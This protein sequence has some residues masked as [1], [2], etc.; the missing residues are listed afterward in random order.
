MCH[1]VAQ[2]INRARTSCDTIYITTHNGTDLFN[3]FN[4]IYKC[5]HKFLKIIS[6]LKSNY[7]NFKAGI[8][9]EIRYGITKHNM[10]E[11]TLILLLM[12]IEL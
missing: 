8:A 5:K 11:D 3:N 1:K 4:K 2:K 7:H 10:E 6:D 12:E 9:L